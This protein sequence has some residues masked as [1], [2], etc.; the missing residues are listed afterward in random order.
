VRWVRRRY[1]YR[2]NLPILYKF[3]KGTIRLDTQLTRLSSQRFRPD[4]RNSNQ[5]CVG[6]LVNGINVSLADH[7]G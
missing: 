6:S 2:V 5:D 1:D 3:L 7:P 4:R